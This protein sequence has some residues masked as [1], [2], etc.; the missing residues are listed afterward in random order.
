VAQEKKRAG[1]R[2]PSKGLSCSAIACIA[3][4]FLQPCEARAHGDIPG[5]ETAIS[6][7]PQVS[8]NFASNG[9]KA[10][11]YGADL[12]FLYTPAW[13]G[14]GFKL[15]HG[16]DVI[17]SPYVEAGF[18]FLVNVGMGYALSFHDGET[19]H[20]VHLFIGEPIPLN[21]VTEAFSGETW[22]LMGEPYYRRTWRLDSDFR[23]NEL[24]I[25]IKFVVDI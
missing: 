4:L 5:G 21:W 20:N 23:E 10:V 8:Y 12:A 22:L 19:D 15:S 7:G 18:W 17:V 9:R 2:L 16:D 3:W 24:G 11:G 25:L 1:A 13:G 14:A 6:V